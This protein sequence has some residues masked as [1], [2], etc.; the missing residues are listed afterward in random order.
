MTLC[1]FKLLFS[2]NSRVEKE[3]LEATVFESQQVAK[4]LEDRCARA[5]EE[6]RSL[7]LANEALTRE[8]LPPTPITTRVHSTVVGGW[9]SRQSPSGHPAF[10]A[11]PPEI[12][13]S[14]VSSAAAG[15]EDE[16]GWV[17]AEQRL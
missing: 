16:R 11:A 15:L 7:V 17:S 10:P 9:C 1:C 13:I 6:R 8:R 4:I 5:E 14:V 3:S 12:H 2:P